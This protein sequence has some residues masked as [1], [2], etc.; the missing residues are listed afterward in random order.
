MCGRYLISV[1]EE[2]IEMR[3]II[4]EINRRYAG[5]P[6]LGQMKSGEI[7]PT[8]IVPVIALEAEQLRPY[9]FSWG[10]PR[11]QE[12]GVIINARSETA[13]EKG[14]FRQALQ[15][16]RCII[17]ASGFYEWRH[18]GNKKQKD[19]YIFSRTETPVLYM[20]GIYTFYKKEGF[21]LPAFV[22]LTTAANR[23]VQ[24]V[25]NRMPVII[26]G[27]EQEMWLKDEVFA[28]HVLEREGPPLKMIGCL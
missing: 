14:M 1:E 13:E 5:Q 22:I 19:K 21:E 20:A 9:L 4:H 10:F 25:H 15:K 16:R 23:S 7:F 6:E 28:R 12:S 2:I 27:D 3:E 26:A 17:P 8:D 24:P 18:E 11:W